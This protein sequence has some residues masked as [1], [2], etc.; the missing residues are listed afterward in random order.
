MNQS[1]VGEFLDHHGVKGMKWGVRKRRNESKRGKTFGGGGKKKADVPDV[2]D[3]PD[4]ELQQIVN[5]MNMERQFKSLTRTPNAFE[6]TTKT[7]GTVLAVGATVNS[8][9]AFSKSP[10]GQAIKKGLKRTK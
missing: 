9:I 5:R 8:A 1:E 7:V 10:A 4:K 6:K 3:I 2:K